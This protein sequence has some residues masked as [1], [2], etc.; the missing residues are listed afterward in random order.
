MEKPM[1]VYYLDEWF[2]ELYTVC[3]WPTTSSNVLIVDVNSVSVRGGLKFKGTVEYWSEWEIFLEDSP[4][5]L[6]SNWKYILF[7]L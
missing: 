5:H 6:I 2:V 7:A 4:F 3:C 1:E